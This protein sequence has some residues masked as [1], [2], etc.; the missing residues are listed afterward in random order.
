MIDLILGM[1]ELGVD[2]FVLY[3][4]K[5]DLEKVLVENHIKSRR[6]TLPVWVVSKENRLKSL[7]PFLKKTYQAY[8]EIRITVIEED[9]SHIY[10]NSSVVSLG[11]VLSLL[12]KI[13]HIW[14]I[15]ELIEQH[16]EKA[17]LLPKNLT[18][19]I[20]KR[21][22]IIICNSNYVKEQVFKQNDDSISVIY[23]GILPESVF[24]DLKQAKKLIG[25]VSPFRFIVVGLVS[26]NKNQKI[27]I[28]AINVLKRQGLRV[29]L[30]IIGGGGKY[31]QECK[32]MVNH[33]SLVNEVT[34]TG[35]IE[36]PFP[37]YLHSSCLLVCSEYEAMGRVTVEGMACCLPVIGKK[38]GGTTELIQHGKTGFLY[39]SFDELVNYMELLVRNQ[40]LVLT[41]GEN[42][43][44]YAKGKFSIE[45]YSNKILERI[46]QK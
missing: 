41:I 35:Y 10:S 28:Q 45:N 30:S 23:N 12:L 14:H 24:S 46:S 36:N 22:D 27:A 44:S 17:Y 1:R 4:E 29:K 21:S 43:W 7:F 6:L 32:E 13:P 15:R 5:G 9:I 37:E 18:K 40:S 38:S 39:D 19:T 42:G 31:L 20:I 33:L 16:Y 26:K 25:I 34:F 11:I 2:S 8:R 3:P